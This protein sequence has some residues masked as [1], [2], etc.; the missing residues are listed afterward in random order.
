[1]A[2]VL[3]ELIMASVR[4]RLEQLLFVVYVAAIVVGTTMEA[5]SQLAAH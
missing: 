5:M 4:T 3:G 2:S 1:M